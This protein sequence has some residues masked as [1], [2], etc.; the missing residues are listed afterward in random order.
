[1]R[2]MIRYGQGPRAYGTSSECKFE[3]RYVPASPPPLEYALHRREARSS[4][5]PGRLRRHAGGRVLQHGSSRAD[6]CSRP[7]HNA[8]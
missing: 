3:R 1:M 7:P 5:C 2:R 4:S 8:R 6:T